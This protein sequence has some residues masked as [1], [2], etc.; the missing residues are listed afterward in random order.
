[1]QEA[2]VTL[3]DPSITQAAEHRYR[4]CLFAAADKRADL[5]ASAEDILA[6][7]EADC[8]SD[9]LAY[10]DLI[11][12]PASSTQHTRAENQFKNDKA[13]AQLRAMQLN[14]RRLI[15]DH[16]GLQSLTRKPPRSDGPQK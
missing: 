1:M 10:A 4:S 15:I 8:R 9:Y 11:H 14:M 3:A 13:E 7:A 2:A 16:I 12:A 6:A 5:P